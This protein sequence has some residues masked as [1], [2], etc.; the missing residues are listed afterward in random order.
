MLKEIFA[1]LDPHKKGYLSE[2]DFIHSFG[3]FNWKSSV[4][5]EFLETLQIKFKN[6]HEAF[7]YLCNYNS[8][9]VLTK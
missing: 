6:I 5:E 4:F 3:N 7:K 1:A 8:A 9:N 2:S